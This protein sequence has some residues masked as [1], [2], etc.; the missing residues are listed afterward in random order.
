MLIFY[1]LLFVMQ[2]VDDDIQRCGSGK[3][4][5]IDAGV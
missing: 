5:S 3:A 1:L 4:V 2:E